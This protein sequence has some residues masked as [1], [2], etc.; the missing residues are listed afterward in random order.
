M[1]DELLKSDEFLADG[2]VVFDSGPAER[3]C[4]V[5]RHFHGGRR[6]EERLTSDSEFKRVFYEH[7]N[8]IQR[9]A[10]ALLKALGEDV[11]LIVEGVRQDLSSAAGF[12]INC[13]VDGTLAGFQS[14]AHL[15]EHGGGTLVGIE[16]AINHVFEI[17]KQV[18]GRV[19]FAVSP[20]HDREITRR[21]QDKK[22]AAI[23][24]A[25]T[26]AQ[27]GL[28]IIGASHTVHGTAA[29]DLDVQSIEELFEGTGVRVIVVEPRTVA[30]NY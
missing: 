14:A 18:V 4:V 21:I 22:N 8:Q 25:M 12:F 23:V 6:D 27:T 1:I 3:T 15:R 24:R 7:Q 16:P 10:A 17:V 28:V 19:D 26:N 29:P 20:E 5:F 9:M 30:W 13:D 2:A 11:S